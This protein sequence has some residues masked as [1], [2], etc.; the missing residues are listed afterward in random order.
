MRLTQLTKQNSRRDAVSATDSLRCKV[1]DKDKDGRQACTA[2]P[3]E[4]YNAGLSPLLSAAVIV[5]VADD[6][7]NVGSQAPGTVGAQTAGCNS[8]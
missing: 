2:V 5:V 8:R 6:S 4:S 7:E 1:D 3:A